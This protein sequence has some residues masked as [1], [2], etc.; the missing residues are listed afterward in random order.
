VDISTSPVPEIA[1]VA[2]MA[3]NRIIGRNNKLIWRIPEDMKFFR[4][5][6]KG[7]PVVMGRLTFESIGKPLPG[8]RNIVLT[9]NPEFAA[10]GVETAGSV[11]EALALASGTTRIC[12]IGGGMVYEAFLPYSNAMYLTWIHHSVEG[13]ASF[14]MWDETQWRLTVEDP[15][16]Y[17]LTNPYAYSFREYR[18]IT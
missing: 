12:V 15:G 13:D 17:T 1:L 6:T 11:E 5:V 8:R 16:P 4:S 2:A 7:H 3:E 14:P 10:E 9:R 18:R